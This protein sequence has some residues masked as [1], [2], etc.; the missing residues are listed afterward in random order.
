MPARDA[1]EYDS[2]S[3]GSRVGHNA[4]LKLPTV[5]SDEPLRHEGA[6][7]L[8]AAETQLIASQMLAIASGGEPIGYRTLYYNQIKSRTQ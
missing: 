5:V 7:W 8:K 3:G 4:K 6:E 1:D 2:T